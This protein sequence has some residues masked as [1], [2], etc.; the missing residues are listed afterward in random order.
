[1]SAYRAPGRPIDVMTG[2]AV[3][4]VIVACPDTFVYPVCAEFAVTTTLPAAFGVTTPPVV[5]VAF[6]VTVQVTL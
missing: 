3:V 6:D 5:M 1:M 4:T 2:T